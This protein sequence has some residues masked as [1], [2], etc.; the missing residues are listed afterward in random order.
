MN[1]RNERKRDGGRERISH[2]GSQSGTFTECL[3]ISQVYLVT[4]H[5]GDNVGEWEDGMG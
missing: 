4:S 3:N 5:S 1:Q 2:S